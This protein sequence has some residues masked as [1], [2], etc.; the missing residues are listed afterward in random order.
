MTVPIGTS[1]PCS[2]SRAPGSRDSI[3]SLPGSDQTAATTALY[4]AAKSL[5][6]ASSIVRTFAFRHGAGELVAAP[7]GFADCAHSWRWA[8]RWNSPPVSASSS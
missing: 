4:R 6:S 1:I 3:R 8:S 2:A 5:R 7:V